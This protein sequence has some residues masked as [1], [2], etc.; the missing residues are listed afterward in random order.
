MTLL[1][2][3]G[4]VTGSTA[5]ALTG[6]K[7][8]AFPWVLNGTGRG[9][10]LTNKL[11]YAVDLSADGSAFNLAGTQAVAWPSKRAA[12]APIQMGS[13]SVSGNTIKL[14]IIGGSFGKDQTFIAQD[15]TGTF[16]ADCNGIDW[17]P[18]GCFQGPPPAKGKGR[19]TPLWCGAW[20]DDACAQGMA[21][22]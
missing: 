1:A 10:T 22:P 16:S 18:A 3:A 14:K 2:L 11:L 19:V 20:T 21:P 4:C 6:C 8:S 7:V 15:C 9:N 12:V 17:G 5:A 13:G